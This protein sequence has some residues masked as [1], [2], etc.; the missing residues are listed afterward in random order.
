MG[1]GRKK[2]QRK[3]HSVGIRQEKEVTASAICMLQL[4][5]TKLELK[6]RLLQIT[7]RNFIPFCLNSYT[8]CS[9]DRTRINADSTRS[10]Q[11]ALNWHKLA[12]VGRNMTGFLHFDDA[13][14]SALR[15]QIFQHRAH[16]SKTLSTTVLYVDQTVN[17]PLTVSTKISLK[18]K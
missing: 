11:K 9:A 13:H 15:R 14:C 5:S 8:D 12:N 6:E 1:D 4:Q 7:Q 2:E 17:K 16:F 10:F 18:T 3:K